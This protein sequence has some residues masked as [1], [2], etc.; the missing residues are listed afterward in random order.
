VVAGGEQRHDRGDADTEHRDRTTGGGTHG[1][2]LAG[3]AVLGAPPFA[4][5]WRQRGPLGGPAVDGGR[6]QAERGEHQQRRQQRA[7][8]LGRPG[9]RADDG[10]QAHQGK[11]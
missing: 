9:Q 4:E 2:G 11:Q 5:L 8:E 7:A 6:G 3:P 10:G 1:E